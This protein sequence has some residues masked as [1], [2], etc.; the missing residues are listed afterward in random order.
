MASLDNALSDNLL[1]VYGLMVYPSW[2]GE[3]REA[4]MFEL[5]GGELAAAYGLCLLAALGCVVCGLINWNRPGP[6]KSTG[7]MTFSD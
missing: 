5:G 3:G 6:N 1:F 4:F 2:A 7:G